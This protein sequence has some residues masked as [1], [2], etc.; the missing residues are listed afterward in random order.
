M[1]FFCKKHKRAQGGE[2]YVYKVELL[3][4]GVV[5]MLTPCIFKRGII[6][7]LFFVLSL[8]IIPFF[9]EDGPTPQAPITPQVKVQ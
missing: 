8:I 4:E 1:L 7:I 6:W 9:A 3:V 5:L 2:A